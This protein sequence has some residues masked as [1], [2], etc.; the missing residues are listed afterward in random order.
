MD[1]D[2]LFLKKLGLAVAVQFIW[3]V[4]LIAYRWFRGRPLTSQESPPD[5]R[6]LKTRAMF[7]IGIGVMGGFG[8]SGMFT[9]PFRPI[10]PSLL[11]AFFAAI[12]LL[13][14]IL[15]DHGFINYDDH[16]Q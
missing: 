10:L 6:K 1:E 14:F 9:P 16:E 4:P 13:M 5:F 12:S 8:I 7:V 3:I 11:C 2:L 15:V